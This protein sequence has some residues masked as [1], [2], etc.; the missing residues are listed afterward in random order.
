[1]TAPACAIRMA[2][3]ED[4]PALFQLKRQMALAEDAADTLR[5][6]ETDWQRDMFGA[7]PRFVGLMA[8]VDGG[9]IGMATLVERYYPAWAGPLFA[10][11][12]VFVTPEYRGRGV[13]KALLAHAAAETL[14]R[15]APFIELTVRT[16][17]P[18]RR[19]YESLGF[20][21]VRGAMIYV[22]TGN[23]LAALAQALQTIGAAI[24]A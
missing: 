7:Q 23:A 2:R 8:E 21:P 19:L 11:D 16:Q 15:G 18:A 10:L 6:S 9:P 20:Q 12:D 3:P 1:M 14:R 4:I 24:S 13:G 22:L 5:A 17:N